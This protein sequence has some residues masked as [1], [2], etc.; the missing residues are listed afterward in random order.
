[1]TVRNHRFSTG[2]HWRRGMFLE[3]RGHDATALVVHRGRDLTLTVRAPSPDYFF[4]VLRESL[5]YLARRR[6]EGL[7]YELLVP[8]PGS[9]DRAGDSARCGGFLEIAALQRYRER[10]I[11]QIRCHRCLGEFGV[12]R[13]LT[14]FA[15]PEP[16]VAQV[17][18]EVRVLA[19][20]TRQA[21]RETAAQS[22]EIA[23]GF[24]ALL[25]AAASEG[26]D[27]PRLFTLVPRELSGWKLIK[28]GKRSFELTLWCEHPGEEHPWAPATYEFERPKE[29]LAQIAPYAL[30][31]SRLLRLAVPIGA[32]ALGAFMDKDELEDMRKKLELMKA[33]VEK[34]PEERFVSTG[35]PPPA[36]GYGR[37]HR[38]SGAEART[39]RILLHELDPPQ[40]LGDLRKVL[41]PSGEHLWVCPRVHYRAY[42]PGLPELPT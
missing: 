32:A 19:E 21:R 36:Y 22:A 10:E 5:E 13:L 28:F 26:A 4:A 11:A 12:T 33:L 8:C 35:W 37:L 30:A 18:A 34:L 3:H 23:S 27:C 24:R 31:V 17:V 38:A 6:W 29:W 20:E 9:G 40:A 39:L 41:A 25:K 7:T 1:M 16:E 42:D 2:R 15:L 14:G